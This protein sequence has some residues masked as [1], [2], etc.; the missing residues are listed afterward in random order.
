MQKLGIE[1]ASKLAIG[2]QRCVNIEVQQTIH[3][4]RRVQR[5]AGARKRLRPFKLVHVRQRGHSIAR[6]RA[7][8]ATNRDDNRSVGASACGAVYVC[9]CH[10]ATQMSRI[11]VTE[12]SKDMGCRLVHTAV[13]ARDVQGSNRFQRSVCRRASRLVKGKGTWRVKRPW[14]R[15]WAGNSRCRAE[16]TTLDDERIAAVDPEG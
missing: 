2:I 12:N 13:D 1:L 11:H 14:H 9:S 7:G 3:E 6:H 16:M 10:I 4:Q 8:R 5:N 15:R